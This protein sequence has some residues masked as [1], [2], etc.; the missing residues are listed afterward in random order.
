MEK[1][2][3]LV[4]SLMLMIVFSLTVVIAQDEFEDIE[5]IDGGMTP[6]SVFYFIDEFFDRFGDELEVKEEKVKEKKEEKSE[7][8][9]AKKE[10]EAAEGLASLF[11]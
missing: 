10:E 11:G 3:W 8:E 6:D 5:I 9:E 7:E 1:R 4:V 2:G